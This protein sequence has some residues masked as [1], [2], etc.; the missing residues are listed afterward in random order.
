MPPQNPEA[1]GFLNAPKVATKRIRWLS[2][3]HPDY[4]EARIGVE[5]KDGRHGFVVLTAHKH[6]EPR[7]Y[8]FSLIHERE[9]VLGLDVNPGTR[10]FDSSSLKTIEGTHWNYLGK[11]HAVQDKSSKSHRSWLD[12][13]FRKAHIDYRHGYVPP[14]FEGNQPELGL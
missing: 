8:G 12:E 11:P 5:T 13:F 4:A 6:R 10:Y 3:G 14:P 9:R 1:P 2:A 7:K